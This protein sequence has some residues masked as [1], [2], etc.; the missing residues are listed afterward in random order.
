MASQKPER[1][2]EPPDTQKAAREERA[3]KEKEFDQRRATKQ[4]EFDNARKQAKAAS[5]AE[6]E[7]EF[8]KNQF[9]QRTFPSKQTQFLGNIPASPE[10]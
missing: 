4:K 1:R 8:R 7:E 2:T 10:P 6:V 3:K 9:L 5:R